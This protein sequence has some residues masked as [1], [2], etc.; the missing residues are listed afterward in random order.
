[1]EKEVSC[2]NTRTIFEY[3]RACN[4]GDCS[5]LLGNLDPEIDALSHQEEFLCDPNNWISCAVAAELHRRAKAILN[6]PQTPYKIARFA[7][8][9]AALGY[10]QK[11]FVKAFWSTKTALRHVQKINDKFNR[12]KKVELVTVGRTEA[13]V[14]L[15]WDRTMGVSRDLCLYNQGTYSFMPLTWGSTPLALKETC[16]SFAGA[17]YCEYHLKWPGR[18]WFYEIF[19]RFYTSNSVIKETI[20]EMESDKKIIEHKYEEVSRL[21]QELNIKIKQLTAMQ[22]TGKAILSVLDLEQLLSVI[23]NL[24][25]SVCQINRAIL[26]LVNEKEGCLEYIHGVGFDQ[27]AFEAIKNY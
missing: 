23:M 8:E 21:N 4:K 7:I 6:D 14:R 22:E 9:N 17:D 18:N 15:H 16:C 27:E 2:V 1:M 26:M 13:V 25:F 10:I 3:V 12:S 19:S 20:K 5:G 24:L 11:I